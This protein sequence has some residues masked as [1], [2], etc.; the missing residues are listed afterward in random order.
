MA[1]YSGM[2]T[3]IMLSVANEPILMDVVMLNVVILNVMAPFHCAVKSQMFLHKKSVHVNTALVS[4]HQIYILY[5]GT[6]EKPEN[7][8]TF[9]KERAKAVSRY[10][11]KLF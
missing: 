9:L 6:P 1:L 7:Q 11:K 4:F 10:H 2:L 3:V 8:N 5:S